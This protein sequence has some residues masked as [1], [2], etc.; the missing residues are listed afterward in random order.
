MGR[1]IFKENLF[2]TYSPEI[3]IRCEEDKDGFVQAKLDSLQSDPK[4]G[5][6]HYFLMDCNEQNRRGHQARLEGVKDMDAFLRTLGNSATL[7]HHGK[8]TTLFVLL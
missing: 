8:V 6:M 7:Y 2:Y 1:F 3:Q 5:E 4:I